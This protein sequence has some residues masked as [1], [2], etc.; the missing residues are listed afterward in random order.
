MAE[1]QGYRRGAVAALA[2]L[3]L[4]LSGCSV[5]TAGPAATIATPGPTAVR[6][7]APIK[8]G[9]VTPRTGALAEYGE[10]DAYVID[11]MTDYFDEHPVTLANGTTHPIEI[12]TKDTKSDAET[13]IAAAGELI[14]EDEVTLILVSSTPETVDPVANVCEANEVVCISTGASWQAFYFGRGGTP[15]DGFDYT[16]HFFSGLEDVQAVYGDIWAAT[17]PAD[18]G[19]GLLL[20]NAPDG[21]A[22]RSPVAGIPPFITAQGRVATVPVPYELGSTDF[23]TQIGAFQDANDMILAGVPGATDFATF[24]AQAAALGYQ[25]TT[26]T[27]SNALLFPSGLADLPVGLGDDLSTE[28]WWHPTAAYASS[29]TG[30]SAQELAD[31]FEAATGEHWTQPL[32]F[33]EALFE[34]AV[35]VLEQSRSLSARDLAATIRRLELDTVVGRIDWRTGPVKNVAKLPLVGGQWRSNASGGYDLVVVTNTYAPAIPT[36]GEPEPIVW[37]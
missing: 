30:E 8:I 25:P 6:E 36:G 5:V 12:I 20:P 16:Y 22:W 37:K 2:S 11:T 1:T 13:A 17:A 19:V 9:Y 33:S 15:E 34:V 21:N 14:L 35:A 18:S 31:A 26:A 10:A 27:I 32:G 24:W 3:A 7:G 29:L 4:V 28:V 23:G